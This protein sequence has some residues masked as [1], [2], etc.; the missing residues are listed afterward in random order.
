MFMKTLILMIMM[1][2]L[3]KNMVMMIVMM[4]S[5]DYDD[6][7]VVTNSTKFPLK[8]RELS[9]QSKNSKDLSDTFYI[10]LIHLIKMFYSIYKPI[11]WYVSQVWGY[12]YVDFI[13]A[14]QNTFCKN[15]LSKW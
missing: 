10:F 4:L 2:F 7:G 6:Y 8:L 11:L 14:L 15:I 5:Y 13:G 9:F 12:E 1:I 3:Q